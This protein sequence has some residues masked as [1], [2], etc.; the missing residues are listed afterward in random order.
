MN[1]QI[2]LIVNIIHGIAPVARQNVDRKRRA[3]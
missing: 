2:Y 1:E 3:P